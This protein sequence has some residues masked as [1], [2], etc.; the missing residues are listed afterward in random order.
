MSLLFYKIH[1]TSG[2]DSEM[3][4][5]ND[6]LTFGLLTGNHKQKIVD[7]VF[8]T[9]QTISKCFLEYEKY[10]FDYLIIDEPYHATSPTHGKK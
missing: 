2:R 3:L 8:A 7:Y 5:P 10:E 1:Q 4:L 9:V 6:G